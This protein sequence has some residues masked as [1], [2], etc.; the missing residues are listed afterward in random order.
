M[1]HRDIAFEKSKLDFDEKQMVLHMCIEDD[2]GEE[3][4]IDVPA[5]FTVCPDCRGK[6]TCVNPDIDRHGL[7]REDFSEDPDF[8]EAYY[9]GRYDIP[10]PGCKGLRVIPVADENTCPPDIYAQWLERERWEYTYA[11]ERVREREMGY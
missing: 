2:D 3:Q 4:I 5:K 8:E 9:R 10:C 7:S 6:G 1:D 11:C